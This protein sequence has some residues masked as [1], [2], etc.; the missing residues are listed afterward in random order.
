MSRIT[1]KELKTDKFAL[2]VEHSSRSSKS[3]RRRLASTPAIAVAV[4][5][6]ILGYTIYPAARTWRRARKRWRR[7]S[8]S[9]K[10]RSAPSGNGGHDLP[11]PGRQGP[12]I[13]PRVHRPAGASTPAATKAR[14]RSTTWARIKADQGKLA[15]AEKTLPGGR[16]EGRRQVRLAGQ[17][18]AGPDLLLRRPRRSGG[19]D[20]CAT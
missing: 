16:A 4:V 12:G 17:V 10:P 18:L 8:R 6:L 20:C 19:E 11:H 13:D 14:S 3:T 5:V 7:R 15:E 2:E 1:R 9:R